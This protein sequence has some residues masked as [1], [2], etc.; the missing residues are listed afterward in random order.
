MWP[1][2]LPDPLQVIHKQ[3]ISRKPSELNKLSFV[4]KSS[5]GEKRAITY[6]ESVTIKRIDNFQNLILIFRLC[7]VKMNFSTKSILRRGAVEPEHRIP[8]KE[9]LKLKIKKQQRDPCQTMPNYSTATQ[10]GFDLK[11]PLLRRRKVN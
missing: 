9:P 8:H 1:S 10:I 3:I 6:G 7:V 11:R 5:L 2:Y 4:E